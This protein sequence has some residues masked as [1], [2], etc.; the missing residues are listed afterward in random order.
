[1][2]G[3]QRL[4][5]DVA[6]FALLLTFHQWIRDPKTQLLK[7]LNSEEGAIFE[8]RVTVTFLEAFLMNGID[9]SQIAAMAAQMKTTV[10]RMQSAAVPPSLEGR[11]LPRQSGVDFAQAL[12]SQLDH[13]NTLDVNAQKLGERF[14]L[15]DDNVNL[16]DVMM[17]TQKSSIAMQATIQVR[18]KLVSAYHDIMNMQI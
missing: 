18:N 8:T 7:P 2:H 4:I 17:A 15:G 14:S 9:T 1:M 16:S 12:K 5:F 6:I 10:A 3:Q 13:V 11:V